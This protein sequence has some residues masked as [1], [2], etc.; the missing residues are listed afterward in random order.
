MQRLRNNPAGLRNNVLGLLVAVLGHVSREVELTFGIF[1]MD[2]FGGSE[3]KM[4][5]KRLKRLKMVGTVEVGFF[6]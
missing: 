6:F 5:K 4:L 2:F 1:L 3:K